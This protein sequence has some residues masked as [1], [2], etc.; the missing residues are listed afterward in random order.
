MMLQMELRFVTDIHKAVRPMLSNYILG[1]FSQKSSQKDFLLQEYIHMELW[2]S[3][4]FE[5]RANLPIYYLLESIFQVT[6]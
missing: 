4:C 3:I 6:G 1:V 5:F 2:F